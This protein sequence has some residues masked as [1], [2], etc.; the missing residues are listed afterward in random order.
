MTRCVAT[1]GALDK[2]ATTPGTVAPISEKDML[3]CQGCDTEDCCSCCSVLSDGWARRVSLE[4]WLGFWKRKVK[5]T[6]D[7]SGNT[8]L[9][10]RLVHMFGNLRFIHDGLGMNSLSCDMRMTMTM[11]LMVPRQDWPRHLTFQGR[12]N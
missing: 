7:G 1:T 9:R 12:I 8:W 4:A 11:T 2:N 10:A 6:E 3:S 5:G